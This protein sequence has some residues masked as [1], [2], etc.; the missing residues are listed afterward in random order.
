MLHRSIASIFLAL[1]FNLLGCTVPESVQSPISALSFNIRYGTAKDGENHWEKR[2][3]LVFNVF[4]DHAP[5]VAGLQEALD[6]QIDEILEAHPQFDYVGIGREPGG[7]GEFCAILY[8]KEKFDVLESDTFWLSD[9][10][11]TPSASWG[12]NLVRICTY[13]RFRQRSNGKTFYVFNTHFDHQSENARERSA[14][15]IAERIALRPH[16][17]EPYILMGDFNAGEDK[18]TILTLLGKAPPSPHFKAAPLVD[19]FRVLHPNA[20]NVGT[21]NKWIG[22]TTQAKIDYVFVASTT[23]VLEAEIIHDNENGRYPSDHFPVKATLRFD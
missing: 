18:Q 7:E 15:L 17:D 13:A 16:Q 23:Q 5:D 21:G 19:T 3:P 14:L 20:D 1:L 22:R 8:L 2:H 11:E 4:N 12:N 9:T 10:P 6:F